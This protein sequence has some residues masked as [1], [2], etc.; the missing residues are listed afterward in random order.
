MALSGCTGVFVGFESLND[1]SIINTGKRTPMP[2]DYA[3]RVKML[4]DSGI[5]VSGSFVLGFDHD[6][7]DVFK[8]TID[9]IEENRLETATFHILTPYPATPL[10]A[11]MEREGRL[12][13]KDW[14]KYDTGN[15]V[16]QPKHMT[17]EQL[18]EGYEYAYDRLFSWK[19]IWRRRPQQLAAVPAY[20][21][22]SLLY[23]KS[24]WLWR[25]LIK[26]RL[27]HALW[28]PLI[29]ISR[30]RHVKFREQLRRQEGRVIEPIT[31]T[32]GSV[33]DVPGEAPVRRD[34]LCAGR[35][36]VLPGVDHFC[37][38]HGGT[39]Q[40]PNQFIK[41]QKS[42]WRSIHDPQNILVQV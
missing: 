6:R 26:H 17:P 18:R 29:E 37:R 13:H 35:T 23:K 42:R 19:S 34:V 9:W 31:A 38:A 41:T 3:R 5:Q 20:L 30:W 1:D 14:S 15:V 11:D 22:G 25:L 8:K 24:N 12:L 40:I 10:F 7:P 16:Y 32:A 27:T 33:G 39:V 36:G 2:D 4:H 28:K 21:A